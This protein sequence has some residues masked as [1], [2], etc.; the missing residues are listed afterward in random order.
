MPASLSI[1]CLTDLTPLWEFLAD[2]ERIKVLHAGR[3]DLEV[4]SQA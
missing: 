4:L 2:R 1:R 3:Q